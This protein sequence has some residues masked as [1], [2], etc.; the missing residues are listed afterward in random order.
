[1][2]IRH[3]LQELLLE[4]LKL[5]PSVE[6]GPFPLLTAVKY[7]VDSIRVRIAWGERDEEYLYT[8]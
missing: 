3:A 5:Q 2:H 1:M 4:S 7:Y 6:N 8:E